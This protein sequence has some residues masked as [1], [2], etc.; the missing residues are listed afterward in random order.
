MTF[1]SRIKTISAG[2][3][4]ALV[5]GAGT[6]P[7][8]LVWDGGVNG[9]WDVGT[10]ANWSGPSVFTN[11]DAV[12]F[13]D[14]ATGTTTI[15]VA[16]GGVLPGGMTVGNSSLAYSIGGGAIGGTG[17]LIKLGTGMLTMS[18]A[19]SFSGGTTV[20]AGSLIA[21]NGGAFGSGPVALNDA[22]TG[23]ADTALLLGTDIT[24]PNAITVSSLGTGT[25]IIGSTNS[26]A[27]ANRQFNGIL[28]LERDVVL[29]AGASDRTTFFG[30]ITGAGDVII[31]SPFANNRR[32]VFDRPSGAANDWDG[33]LILMDNARLQLG[34][35][36]AIG[37]RTVPDDASIIF[38]AG[39][40][41][42]LAPGGSG[43]S[44]TVGTL[45]SASA[46]AGRVD[47]F[48]GSAFTLGIGGD[49]DDGVFSGDIINTAGSLSINKVGTG[50]QTL[51]GTAAHSGTTTVTEGTL[52]VVGSITN[53][54]A[55]LV[56][57]DGRLSGTGSI[58][59]PVN[60][61]GG[62]LAPGYSTAFGLG[63]LTLAG[64]L[65]FASTW[66]VNLDGPDAGLLVLNGALNANLSDITLAPGDLF[67][68]IANIPYWLLDN[69]GGTAL[70]PGDQFA[71]MIAT[72]PAAGL[73]PTASGF[74]ELDG[75]SFAV[76]LGADF[77]TGALSGGNDIVLFAIPEPGRALLLALA[78][79]PLLL[80]RRR[81]AANGD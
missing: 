55:V 72:S 6:A 76:F 9:T 29:Q 50:T 30:Q 11:G 73:Y 41:L 28:T 74:V 77:D 26:T 71:N 48:T 18:G 13:D 15:T 63:S 32:I 38:G 70:V 4:V 60:V 68:P 37:N 16:A 81:P 23:G 78:A 1:G 19:N 35:A 69:R 52:D 56:L 12:L 45:H 22:G 5:M 7:G 36:N 79:V 58:N 10:T 62:T 25:T 65:N 80:R 44:E 3:A 8:Q 14:S 64:P 42:R 54:S 2:L 59:S 34:V 66:E 61:Q 75:L 46:G 27:G 17:N 43:D 49:N 53:S 21:T 39:S 20:R 40:D 31:S 33:N 24:L 57:A 67:N 51:A 47:M